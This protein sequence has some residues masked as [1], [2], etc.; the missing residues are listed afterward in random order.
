MSER[1]ERNQV[2]ELLDKLGSEQDE[3]VC[4]FSK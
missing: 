2:I 3:D 1:L 4:L